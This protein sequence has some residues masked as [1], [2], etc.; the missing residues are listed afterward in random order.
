MYNLFCFK[1]KNVRISDG[2]SMEVLFLGTCARDFAPELKTEFAHKFDLN[3]RRSSSVLL[4]NTILI[5]C[6][7]HTINSLEIVGVPLQNISDILITHLHSDHFNISNIEKIAAARKRNKSGKL[8]LWVQGEAKLPKLRNVCV[9][10]MS[11]GV[12][13]AID[14]SL[15]VTGLNANH[16]RDACPQQL[17]FEQEGKRFLYA[18]DGAWIL[19]ETYYWLKNKALS[20]LV[21]DST[22]G[23]YT[24][25]YRI[26][27]HNSIPMIR[28]M[29]P[30][31][32][33]WGV[34]TESTKIYLSH[35]APS[36]HK[37]HAE[38]EQIVAKDG[39]HLAYDG[40][41]LSIG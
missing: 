41:R 24:G 25:D 33:I 10:K 4:N 17:C 40:L 14:G 35:I 5:D 22:V 16:D 28:L 2:I 32:K 1:T 20:L 39:L 31:L 29:L 27:E 7:E 3:A 18:C 12:T 6:G 23:D 37:S 34:V 21:I 8:R 36:L 11:Y 13:Y 30:S 19:N 9:R 15:Y 38:T 26:G